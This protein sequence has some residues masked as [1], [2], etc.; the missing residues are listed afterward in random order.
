M[1]GMVAER[2]FDLLPRTMPLTIKYQ[3]TE[4]LWKHFGPS[5]R[6]RLRIGLD[7]DIGPILDAVRSHIDEVVVHY[8][9]PENLER[10]FEWLAAG[11]VN[12]KQ[13]LLNHVRASEKA[14]VVEGARIQMPVMLQHLSSPE[15]R[16]TKRLAQVL[17]VGKHE[18]ELL[19]DKKASGVTLE[20]WS[21][22]HDRA[23]A[24]FPWGCLVPIGIVIALYILS[25]IGH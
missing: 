19:L 2:L 1:S 22:I 14:L 18:L 20:E 3:L 17:R 4:K 7:A 13:Q 23:D 16:Q 10:R 12:V 15:G 6:K 21:Y 11:D 24:G 8:R 9:I 25:H 5:S